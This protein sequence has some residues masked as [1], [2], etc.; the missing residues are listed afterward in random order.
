[1]GRLVRRVA[2]DFDHP[3][4]TAWPGFV[5]PTPRP[6]PEAGAPRNGGLGCELGMTMAGRWLERITSL[7]ME[8]GE[9]AR[10]GQVH[11]Y[12]A[13]CPVGPDRRSSPA[14]AD[15]LELTQALAGRPLDRGFGFSGGDT[16][17]AKRKIV[18]AAGLPR[19][20]GTCP[21]C[22]GHNCHPDD[23][24]MVD[25]FVRTFPPA[26]DG[27]QLWEDT[28]EG[29]PIT[30]VFATPEELSVY[31]A[32]HCSVFADEKAPADW[33]LASFKA[34]TTDSDTMM[35]FVVDPE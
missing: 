21:V 8:I 35:M 28:T 2:L 24:E 12:L 22:K 18:A 15:G 23:R 7:I 16:W 6:C 29:S 11:P 26:G 10:R 31:A 14:G 17:A 5:P 30:P 34:G 20:W 1:M 19:E 3:P 9:S 25:G 27:W 32:E 13:N 33:W 4:N